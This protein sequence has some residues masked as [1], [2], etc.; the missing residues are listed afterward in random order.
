MTLDLTQPTPEGIERMCLIDTVAEING[1]IGK[2]RALVMRP[3]LCRTLLE[4]IALAAIQGVL[5][6]KEARAEE[7]PPHDSSHP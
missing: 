2:A 1:Y 7:Q 3:E 4:K 6:S 5:D